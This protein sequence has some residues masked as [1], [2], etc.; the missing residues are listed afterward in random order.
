MRGGATG[1][2]RATGAF[3]GAPPPQ[4][5]PSVE[6]QRRLF[7]SRDSDAS[8]ASSRPSSVGIGRSSD[9]HSDRSN[10]SSMIRSINAFLSSR[11]F[12]ISLRSNPVPSVKDISET[13]IFL[14][15]A[16][17][18]PCDPSKW[19]E[20]VVFY[21]R[22]MNCPYKLTKSS[23]RASNTPHNW[24]TFLGVALWLVQCA[25]FGQHVSSSSSL[26]S[27][28][29]SEANSMNAFGFQSYRHFI[30]GED[31]SVNEI[32]SDFLG[33]F[34]AEKA[35]FAETIAAKKNLL[36][37]LEAKLE[38]R[39]KGPTKK[40]SCKRVKAVLEQD[41]YKMHTMVV[42][43]TD[44]TR[45]IEK[46]V[47]EKAKEA[48]A[49][50]EEK[51]LTREENKELKK[52]V[53]NQSFN[54]RDVERMRREL[55]A[56][57][58]DVAEAESARDGWDQKSWELN[59]QAMNKFHQIQTLAIDFNQDLRRSKIDIQFDV[60][61]RGS[62]GE[63]MG[64]DYKTTVKPALYSLRDSVKASL[65]ENTDELSTFQHHAFETGSKIESEKSLLN[66][67]KSQENKLE[68][69]IDLVKKETR[70]LAKKRDLEVKTMLESLKSEAL[71]IE[72]VENE[73]A[74]LVRGSELRLK[75]SEKQCDEEVKACASQL[76]KLIDSVSKHK[77]YMDSKISEIKTSVDN[78]ASGVAEIYKTGLKRH[79]GN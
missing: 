64:V 72:I 50:E 22:S 27:R 32:D 26:S 38:S 7:N 30:R 31:D 25:R 69:K 17:D 2:R 52:K 39:K 4:P 73:A 74:E 36:G 79:L 19:D 58:R 6:H 21:L 28:L 43:L 56:V 75:E 62:L 66:L 78:T 42:E 37:E 53:E 76:F 70:D 68:E 61:E 24:P 41:V 67:V 14:L 46:L 23:L 34:E 40:E 9:I 8:F 3:G 49:K 12:S 1:K 60:N 35:T 63:V 33:K 18:F 5:P 11:N 20:E 45:G 44:K 51:E 71:N 16:V 65:T 55:Q 29:A 57:E 47:E 54:V 59:S 13:L 10:Q 15:S 77:E 48:K